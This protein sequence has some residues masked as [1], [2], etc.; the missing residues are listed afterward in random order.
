MLIVTMLIHFNNNVG[1]ND[2]KIHI[3]SIGFSTKT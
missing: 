3:C 1:Y 2:I